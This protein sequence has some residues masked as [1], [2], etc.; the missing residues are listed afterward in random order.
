M[1]P[2]P[3]IDELKSQAGLL[4]YRQLPEEYRFRD[5]G[6]N[7]EG[8]LHQECPPPGSMIKDQPRNRRSGCAR[9]GGAC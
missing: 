2:L 8:H 4:L 9:N 1:P 6:Q 5:E 7:G 3:T